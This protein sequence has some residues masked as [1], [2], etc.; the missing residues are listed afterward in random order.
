[1]GKVVSGI[2]RQTARGREKGRTSRGIF[3]EN[4]EV[5]WETD[6]ECSFWWGLKASG[7]VFW[8]TNS[9]CSFLVGRESEWRSLFEV[10][11][12]EKFH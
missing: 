10:V 9:E 8:E 1:M 3:L 2:G 4:G 12:G 11:S 6:S 7:G 5:F